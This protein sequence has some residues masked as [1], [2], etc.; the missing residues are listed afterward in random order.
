MAFA[1]LGIWE[2][3]LHGGKRAYVT[4]DAGRLR[5]HMGHLLYTMERRCEHHPG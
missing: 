4:E 1:L 5:A 2:L 3:E